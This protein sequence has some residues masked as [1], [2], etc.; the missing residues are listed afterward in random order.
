MSLIYG[1]VYV[2]TPLRLASG[3]QFALSRKGAAF[4]ARV[5][6][7]LNANRAAVARAA[8]IGANATADQLDC[9]DQSAVM[10]VSLIEAD[11]GTK[12]G[13]AGGSGRVCLAASGGV[14]GV[15]RVQKSTVNL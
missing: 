4:S 7:E 3:P 2:D 14:A 10:C 8:P 12:G 6:R 5:Q 13:V 1:C 11:T 15:V 9:N